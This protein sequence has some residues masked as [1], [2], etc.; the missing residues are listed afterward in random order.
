MPVPLSQLAVDR[1]YLS[2][3]GEIR[4]VMLIGTGKVTYESVAPT[5]KGLAWSALS[6][7]GDGRFAREALC[8][9][10]RPGWR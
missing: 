6:V 1:C 2:A 5:G 7:I 3:K 4:H 8:E 10:P 9:V